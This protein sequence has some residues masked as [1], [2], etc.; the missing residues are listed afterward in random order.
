LQHSSGLMKE[1]CNCSS[2]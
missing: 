1:V 2:N